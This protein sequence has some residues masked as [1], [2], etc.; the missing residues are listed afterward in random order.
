MNKNRILLLSL[1]LLTLQCCTNKVKNTEIESATNDS[2]IT[3]P[4]DKTEVKEL[5]DTGRGLQVLVVRKKNGNTEKANLLRFFD[6]ELQDIYWAEKALEEAIPKIQS[7][8]NGAEL[9]ALLEEEITTTARNKEKIEGLFRYIG[10][11]PRERKAA[12]MIGLINE[13]DKLI[14]TTEKGAIRDAGLID[15][16]QKMK[17]YEISSFGTLYTLAHTLKLE[18]VTPVLA[19]LKNSNIYTEQQFTALA[20][21]PL[22]KKEIKKEFPYEENPMVRK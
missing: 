5:S 9:I 12:G 10:K 7:N 2:E 8:A 17:Q 15:I 3:T 4:P 1:F 22:K 6:N 19:E 21:A 20:E 16:T 11:E 13:A 14:K 18:N